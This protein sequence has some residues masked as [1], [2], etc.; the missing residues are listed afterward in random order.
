MCVLL[1]VQPWLRPLHGSGQQWIIFAVFIPAVNCGNYSMRHPI[2]LQG[3]SKFCGGNS[4]EG[5]QYGIDAADYWLAA[6][7]LSI[8]YQQVHQP[9]SLFMQQAS[10]AP[11]SL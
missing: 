7:S 9:T 8:G 6:L 5:V 4:T 11:A 10:L 3:L 2:G 1:K